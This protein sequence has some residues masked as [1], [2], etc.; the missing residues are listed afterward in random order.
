[1][2]MLVVAHGLNGV[3]SIIN[4]ASTVLKNSKMN[5]SPELQSLAIPIFLT[6]GITITM[7]IVDRFG[8][9]VIVTYFLMKL[10]CIFG[11]TV[12]VFVAAS[13]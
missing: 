10:V 13:Q 1:M 4:Y 3:F 6:I 9:K 7:T 11:Y 2:F 5:I 12:R 8:R